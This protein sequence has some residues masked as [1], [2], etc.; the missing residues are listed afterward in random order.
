[1]DC[2]HLDGHVARLSLPLRMR[3]RVGQ[4]GNMHA[5][6]PSQLRCD[7]GERDPAPVCFKLT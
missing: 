2:L 5:Y 4:C 1:V 7:T 3:R 6:G